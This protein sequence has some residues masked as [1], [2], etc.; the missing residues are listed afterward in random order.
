MTATV[1]KWLIVGLIPLLA[2]LACLFALQIKEQKAIPFC[3]E[4]ESAG[5]V[6]EISVWENADGVYYVFLPGYAELANTRIKLNTAEPVYVNDIQLSNGMTC[7]AFKVDESYELRFSAWGEERVCQVTFVQSANVATMC[8]DTASGSMKYIHA[9]KGNEETGKIR[10]YTADGSLNYDGELE[11]INGRGNATWQFYEKK[12]YSL[13]L[14]TEA[15]LLNMGKAQKWILLANANDSS[16]MRNKIVF[17]F[18]K[19][20]GL[21]YSPDSQWVDLYLNG[22][23]TGLYLLCERNEIHPERVNISAGNG[24]LVSLE[25]EKRLVDQNYPYVKTTAGQALRI[26]DPKDV[27]ESTKQEIAQVFQSIENAILAE[28]GIDRISGKHWSELIDLDSWV[29]KYLIEEIFANNDACYISQYFYMDNCEYPIYAGPIWDFDKAI[30]A[31]A[32]WQFMTSRAFYANRVYVDAA[33]YT[34]WFSFLYQK[35]EFY[36]YLTEIYESQYLPR[37]IELYENRIED[38]AR[39]IIRADKSNRIRWNFNSD[40]MAE[41]DYMCDFLEQRVSFLSDV[42]VCGDDYYSVCACVEDDYHAYYA[43][44]PGEC[45][46]TLPVLPDNEYQTFLGWYYADTN[47]PF[48]STAPITEDTEIYAK[49]ADS[50]YKRKEQIFKLI[51]LAVIACMGVGVLWADIRRMRK[52]G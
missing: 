45:L 24:V 50:S 2:C 36:N 40:L 27:N 21:A 42:W 48:D 22:E 15:D 44:S 37:I 3:V 47:L 30:G 28:D 31:D 1:R 32:N 26:H 35:N 41:I 52:G 13:Q 4:V 46:T 39:I 7:E 12:P 19:E 18:V 14:Q 25:L 29:R 16:N 17:D 6:E 11:S 43:I 9:E 5:I 34:P 49:W 33:T 51:P 23:Y 38:Q 8:I 20:A 10:L